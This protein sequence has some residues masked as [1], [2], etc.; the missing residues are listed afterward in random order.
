MVEMNIREKILFY[1]KIPTNDIGIMICDLNETIFSVNENKTF[2]SAST[3]K[4]FILSYY[5]DYYKTFDKIIQIPEYK[6]V[7][8]SIITE[9]NTTNATIGKLLILMMASS[10]N[11]ATNI[12][13]ENVGFDKINNYISNLG[14]KNTSLKRYMMDF[15]AVESGLD[16][17][18]T[19]YDTI[20]ILKY[21][22]KNQEA[23][24]IMA[25]QKNDVRLT[26]YIYN[27]NIKFYGKNGELG[28]AF[29]DTGIFFINNNFIFSAVYTR[30]IER[31]KAAELCGLC[32]LLA[33]NESTFVI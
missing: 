23:L 30:N 3:I 14:I 20:I 1:K 17:I 26:R 8:S 5:L 6:Y 15:K 4:L 16:N 31:E 24:E 12:L 29:N 9:L 10:D 2:R 19:A 11:T 33:I 21:L 32:G 25:K 28:N 7:E 22:S 27:D 13:I 18:S